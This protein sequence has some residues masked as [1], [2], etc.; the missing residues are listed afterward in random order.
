MEVNIRVDGSLDVP[1]DELA[2]REWVMASIHQSLATSPTERLLI[3]MENP[4]VD[5]VGHPT[6]RKLNKRAAV[7]LD[8]GRV[9]DKALETRTF[10]E[11]NSQPDRLDLRDVHARLAAERGLLLVVSSDAHETAALGYTELGIGQARRAWLTRDQVLNTRS[12][13]DV[14]RLIG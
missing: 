6:S 14:R 7:E 5:C 10:L 13:P 11:I 3:A 9:V 12:W 1:D 8:V 4:H 2:R